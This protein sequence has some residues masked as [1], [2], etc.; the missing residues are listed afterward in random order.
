MGLLAQLTHWR[1]FT[2]VSHSF[3]SGSLH[4][5]VHFHRENE[6]DRLDRKPDSHSLTRQ[7]HVGTFSVL[8]YASQAIPDE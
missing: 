8:D 5:G 1:D 3:P 2:G 6:A 4:Q 7:H